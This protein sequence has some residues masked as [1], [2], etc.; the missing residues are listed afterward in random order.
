M[1]CK[2]SVTAIHA[3]PH[4]NRGPRKQTTKWKGD[5]KEVESQLYLWTNPRESF[6]VASLIDGPSF[7]YM[8]QFNFHC[9]I[10]LPGF[11]HWTTVKTSSKL[12]ANFEKW[13]KVKTTKVLTFYIWQ[14]KDMVKPDLKQ[15]LPNSTS[16]N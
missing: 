7:I 9:Y 8:A 11:Q 10:T 5:A 12:T 6:T 4:S 16:C 3:D 1:E 14:E 15:T 13:Q 2:T